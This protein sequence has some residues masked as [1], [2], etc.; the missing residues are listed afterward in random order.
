MTSSIPILVFSD[1]DGTLIDHDTYR[2][3]AAQPALDALDRLGAGVILAS[4]KTSAELINLQRSIGLMQWPAIVENGAAILT[5][6]ATDS[7]QGSR[8][9]DL[10]STLDKLPVDLRQCF[11]GFGDMQLQEVVDATGLT[12]DSAMLATQRTYSEPGIWSGSQAQQIKFLELLSRQGIFAREGGRFLTLSYGQTKADCMQQIIKQYNPRYTIALGDAPNDV[13]MLE[14][15]DI[16]VIVANP[17]RNPLPRL[18]NEANGQIIRTE[19]AG[20]Q[21]WN[22]AILGII[23]RLE[24][25]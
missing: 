16:G 20:P 24:I 22:K 4:S 18:T 14:A 5:P 15:A 10:R 1:L 2:W 8:Y 9:A 13:E 23:S 12:I 11:K 25:N 19:L 7:Q 6:N 3:D 21:G 17:H